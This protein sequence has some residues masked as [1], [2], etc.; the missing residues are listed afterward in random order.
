MKIMFICTGNSARSQM[1]EGLARKLSKGSREVYSAGLDPK[2][3]NPH[4]I[5]AM[6]EIGI[7]ITGQRSKE[8]DSSLMSQMDVIVTLCDQAKE[9]CPVTPP[10][11]KTYH[12][13][14]PDPAFFSGT[15]KEIMAQ[16]GKIR[17]EISELVKKLLQ[18]YQVI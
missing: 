1:A 8:V 7:D 2:G 14:L 9:R 10:H 4:A 16:F 13:S 11:I 3:V 18:E 12:W 17:D 6:K 15:E 5:K